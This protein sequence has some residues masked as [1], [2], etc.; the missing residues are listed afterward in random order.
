MARVGKW[1]TPGGDCV[2]PSAECTRPQGCT[3]RGG[4]VAPSGRV[5]VAPPADGTTAPGRGSVARCLALARRT[6]RACVRAVLLCSA[7]SWQRRP[8][9]GAQSASSCAGGWVCSIRRAPPVPGGR[10]RRVLCL[11]SCRFTSPVCVGHVRRYAKV[12]GLS[13][14]RVWGELQLAP[15]TRLQ[16]WTLI[17]RESFSLL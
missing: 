17:S 4:G 1:R 13:A 16:L 9:A 5:A 10:R 2:R 14:G 12:R 8:A 3:A 7:R 6:A 11:V 15:R